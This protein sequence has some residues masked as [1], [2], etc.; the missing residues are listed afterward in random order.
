MSNI[1]SIRARIKSVEST[2]QITKSMKMV[3]VS[4]LRKTQGLSQS[5]REYAETCSDLLSSV[6]SGRLVPDN[7]FLRPSGKGRICYVL[8]VGNRGLC[9]AYNT[10][11]LKYL[12]ELIHTEGNGGFVVTVGRWDMKR[13][14]QASWTYGRAFR[15]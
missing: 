11:V 3:A 5:L 1:R 2:R 6:L 15:T 8:F 7:A 9:G 13:S 10:N 12:A 14:R 4:K